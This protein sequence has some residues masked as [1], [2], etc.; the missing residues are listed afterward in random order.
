MFSSERYERLF[1]ETHFYTPIFH[2]MFTI[3]GTLFAIVNCVLLGTQLYLS[4]AE[5]NFT[6]HTY[7]LDVP[8]KKAVV[9]S[10]LITAFLILN[11][12]IFVVFAAVR[13]LRKFWPLVIIFIVLEQ[14]VNLV[15]VIYEEYDGATFF[16]MN[17]FHNNV[18]DTILPSC[19][20]TFY[21][22]TI[23]RNITSP[24]T[25]KLEQCEIGF[26]NL[27]NVFF[28]IGMF[29]GLA[30]FIDIGIYWAFPCLILVMRLPF[31]FYIFTLLLPLLCLI[32]STVCLLTTNSIINIAGQILDPQDCSPDWNPVR[33]LR[34]TS[35]YN[36][37]IC[38][39]LFCHNRYSE[40]YLSSLDHG[41]I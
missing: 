16:I 12:I 23:V 14:I 10:T 39:S 22:G 15:C 34:I 30:Y 18:T 1:L 8:I 21:N 37:Y 20:E 11:T 36:Y 25:G 41:L 17:H 33:E 7:R 5:T 6:A 2:R 4:N 27:S 13:P 19:H 29:H 38:V 3:F 31:R 28:N 9:T 40:V 26:G 24:S 35:L 32:A